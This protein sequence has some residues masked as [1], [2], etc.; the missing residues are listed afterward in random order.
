MRELQQS[1]E[2]LLNE[3]V[4]SILDSVKDVGPLSTLTVAKRTVA[5][6]LVYA[7][8]EMTRLRHIC[9]MSDMHP[10]RFPRIATR[11][12]EVALSTNWARA[13]S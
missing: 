2:I 7:L 11:C 13:I 5:T 3:Y 10:P 9:R 8:I 6:S 4:S 12:P 1:L